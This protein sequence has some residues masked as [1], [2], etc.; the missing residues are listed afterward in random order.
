MRHG[1]EAAEAAFV[2]IDRLMLNASVSSPSQ[3]DEAIGARFWE[4]PFHEA[5]DG[6]I[7]L[8]APPKVVTPLARMTTWQG[9]LGTKTPKFIS[10]ETAREY[11]AELGLETV[12][13]LQE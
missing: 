4:K 6:S 10:L 12:K 11:F 13:R 5:D 9:S 1:H 2:V 7:V 8:G 3:L